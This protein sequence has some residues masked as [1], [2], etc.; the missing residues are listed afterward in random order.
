[1]EVKV[2]KS[3]E[4]KVTY[5]PNLDGLEKSIKSPIKEQKFDEMVKRLGAEKLRSLTIETKKA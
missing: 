1:M 4:Q 2:K 5:D 3:F